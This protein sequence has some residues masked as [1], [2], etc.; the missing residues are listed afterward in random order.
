MFKFPLDPILTMLVE[1]VPRNVP[2]LFK[3]NVPL[4]VVPPEYVFVPLVLE[5]VRFPALPTVRAP[6]PWRNPLNVDGPPFTVRFVGP[7]KL[8]V[9]APL[10]APTLCAAFCSVTIPGALTFKLPEP[11]VPVEVARSVPLLT[12]VPPVYVFCPAKP[13]CRLRSSRGPFL[14]FR[15]E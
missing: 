5:S 13:A 7:F 9:P 1:L 12:V 3:R 4:I 2:E 11:I 10:S 8:T 6:F 14:P 15:P